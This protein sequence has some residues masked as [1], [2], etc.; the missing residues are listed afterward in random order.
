MNNG[1]AMVKKEGKITVRYMSTVGILTAISAVVMLFEFP[2]WFA[3]EFYKLDFSEVIVAIGA[4]TLGPVA[5]IIIELLKNILN[6][7]LNGTTTAG[8]GE[9]ANFVLGCAFIVPASLIYKYSR[10]LKGALIGLIV[11]TVS[12]ALIGALMNM[13]VLL[14]LY[15]YFYKAPIEAFVEAGKAVNRNIVDLKTLIVFA[16]IPFNL[17][18]A[19]VVSVITLFSYKKLSTIIHK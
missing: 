2:L 16:V 3:P 5:G 15:S 10:T 6:L 18:K 9:F 12:L 1:T 4:F 14:P 17:L 11:G 8:V 13:Y 7:L 19:L